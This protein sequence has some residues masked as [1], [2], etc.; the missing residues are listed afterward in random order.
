MAKDKTI[1]DAKL[2]ASLIFNPKP[3]WGTGDE[4]N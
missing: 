3:K 1:P 4:I 2:S